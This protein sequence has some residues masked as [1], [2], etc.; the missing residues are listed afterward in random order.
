MD[1]SNSNLNARFP[2]STAS[3]MRNGPKCRTSSFRE[4]RLV[5]ILRRDNQTLSPT[6]RRGGLAWRVGR[7][8]ICIFPARP[9][10]VGPAPCGR[11]LTCRRNPQLRGWRNWLQ[12]SPYIGGD[13]HSLRRRGRPL[14]RRSECCCRRIP[15]REGVVPTHLDSNRSRCVGIALSSG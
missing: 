15:P 5:L 9:S 7:I 4:G 14:S 1:A 12:P 11:P 6:E 10:T 2:L 13:N 3:K 8:V